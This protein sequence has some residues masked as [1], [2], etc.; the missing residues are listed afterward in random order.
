MSVRCGAMDPTKL[1]LLGDFELV[2]PS[3]TQIRGLGAKPALVLVCLALSPSTAIR[4]DKLIR[5]LWRDRAE[6]QARASL[7]QALWAIRKAFD[8]AGAASPLIIDGDLVALDAEL[9]EVDVRLLEALVTNGS[10]ESL[11]RAVSLYRGEFLEGFAVHDA[12]FESYL[13]QE[14]ERVHQLGLRSS[15]C[16]LASTARAES[17]YSFKTRS[18]A[19][20]A[21]GWN[22][23][24]SFNR[25]SPWR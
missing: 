14:R 17:G 18:N 10:F 15:S 19:L 16:R 20:R 4:R 3:G 22:V 2:A 21:A 9:I 12:D 13:R 7:R 8:D 23:G 24:P 1:W 6:T 5:L 25:D 11:T